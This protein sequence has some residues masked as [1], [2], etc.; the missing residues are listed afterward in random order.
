MIG[1]V[2][3]KNLAQSQSSNQTTRIDFPFQPQV[4]LPLSVAKVQREDGREVR[5]KSSP[6]PFLRPSSIGRLCSLHPLR[7]LLP[8]IHDA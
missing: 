1:Q 2:C 4:A 7:R 6:C 8:V 3:H 5:I